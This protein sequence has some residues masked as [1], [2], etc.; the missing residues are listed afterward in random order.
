[1]NN[2]ASNCHRSNI[3]EN[4]CSDVIVIGAG[5][6]GCGIAQATAH[7]GLSV[8]VLESNAAPGLETSSNSTKLI[9]GGLRYLETFSFSLVKECLKERRLLL[10]NAPSLVHVNRF[11]IPIYKTSKRSRLM[12]YCGLRLYALLDG[13]WLGRS[14]G[15]IKKANWQSLDALNTDNLKAVFYYQDSQTHDQ[16]LTKAIS[17]SAQQLGAQFHFDV[18]VRS[19]NFANG[20]YK[21]T[22]AKK[23]NIDNQKNSKLQNNTTENLE[24]FYAKSL[25]N[26]A[27]PWVNQLSRLF[28]PAVEML[29]IELVQG[30]HIVVDCRIS[31]SCYYGESPDDGRAVFILPWQGKTL[32]GTTET[33]LTASASSCAASDEEIAYLL[34]FV[35]C[36]FPSKNISQD[37]IVEVFSGVRTLL[38][39]EGD[40]NSLSRETRILASTQ[41]PGYFAL[42]GGKLTV[43]R[44]TSEHLVKQIFKSVGHKL[45]NYK[46]TRNISLEPFIDKTSNHFEV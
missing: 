41:Y 2:A 36:Y 5:V 30:V 10:K 17:K 43:Y 35:Q 42:Y 11:Y 27:G 37:N 12:V 39:G 21:V 1:M 3:I 16:Y 15:C 23:Q 14:V 33:I 8:Q 32:I 44:A 25:V 9:H 34:R 22:V 13:D 45:E 7:N 6:Q 19:I 28:I 40:T 24:A 4:N 38:R 31:E 46:S 18:Q 20:E 29:A 26:A